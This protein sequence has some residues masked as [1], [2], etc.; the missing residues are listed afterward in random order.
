M[1]DIVR[2]ILNGK[3]ERFRVIVQQFSPDL[4]RIAYHFVRDWDEAQDITQNTLL[5]CYENLRRYALERPFRPWLYRIHVN[6]CKAAAKRKHGRLGREVPLTESIQAAPTDFGNDESALILRQIERLS[7]KQKAA[8]ILVEIEGMNSREAAFVLKCADST[9]R[10]HLA[11][12]KKTLRE[13][14]TKL[15]IGYGSIN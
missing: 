2:D 15:G 4:L 5:R 14:L 10:V 11:R 6:V 12:A 3:P 7:V 8:F 1:Q 13:N 9:L